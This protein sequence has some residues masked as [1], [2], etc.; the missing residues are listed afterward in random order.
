[1]AGT[2][3]S[4]IPMFRIIVIHKNKLANRF[5]RS[6]QVPYITFLLE[7]QRDSDEAEI[8][9]KQGAKIVF[10]FQAGACSQDSS[11]KTG[12]LKLLRMSKEYVLVLKRTH[13]S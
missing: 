1:M 5:I 10:P 11:L 9:M 12:I 2:K 3:V 13:C 7:L 4:L 6:C 8:I